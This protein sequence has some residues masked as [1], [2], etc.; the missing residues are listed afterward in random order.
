M[1][2]AELRREF[3]KRRSEL[4][5]KQVGENSRMIADRLF[6][7]ADLR[8]VHTVH[9]FISIPKFNEVDTSLMIRRIW[10]EHPEIRTAAP[11]THLDTGEL[12]HI[13]FSSETLMAENSWGISEPSS[14]V[15]VEP[16]EM[17]LVIVP[18]LC[19]DLTGHRTGYGKGFYDRFL[20]ACRSDCVKIGVS[21]FEPVDRIDGIGGHDIRL[22]ACITPQHTYTF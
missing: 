21:H 5:S 19:F 15:R 12:E 7:A 2:K 6:S 17:D 9:I 11:K 3:L 14:G 18:L 1:S 16:P 20:A 22:D 8:Q 10:L 4:S 13:A